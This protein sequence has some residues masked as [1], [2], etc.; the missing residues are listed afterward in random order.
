MNIKLNWIHLSNFKGIKDFK[1]IADGKNVSVFGNNGTGKTTLQD[2]WTWLLFDKD[3]NNNADTKF[4]IKPQDKFGQD[5]NHLQTVVEAELLVDGQPLKLKKLREEKWVTRHGTTEPVMDGHTK[6]YWFDEVPVKAKEYQAKVDN[7]LNENL[8]KLITNPLHFNTKLKWEERRQILLKIAGDATDEQVIAANQILGP[9]KDIL[10]GRPI[11]QYKLILADKLKELKKEKDDIPPR[12][13]EL[14]R[15]LPQ[16]EPDYTAIEQ[17]LTKHKET[18]QGI[19][20]LLT[21]ATSKADEISKKYQTLAKLNHQLEEVKAKIKSSVGSARETLIERKTELEQGKLLLENGISSLQLEITYAKNRLEHNSQVREN[22]L[23]EYYQLADAKKTIMAE[24][25]TIGEFDTTCPTCGQSIPED[26]VN[27]KIEEMKANFEKDKKERLNKIQIQLEQNVTEGKA[28]KAN[29]DEIQ[30][31]LQELENELKQKLDKANEVVA[32]IQEIELE[33]AK[34]IPEPNYEDFPEYTELMQKIEALKA[35]LDKPIEDKSSELLARKTEI[36]A[37]IDECK[38]LLTGK[39]ETEKKKTRIEQLKAEEK[40]IANLIAELEGHKYLL[41]QFIVTKVNLL[42]DKINSRFK[43]VKFKLFE[44]NIT[45]EGVKETCVALVNT[46]GSYVPYGDANDA[47]KLNSGI[48]IINTLCDF[49]SVRAPIWIDNR[50]R[51]TKLTETDSQVIS[52]I[53]SEPDKVLR[54][55]IDE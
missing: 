10:N 29:T 3:S 16:Q 36:Q 28:L 37:K 11:E 40:R 23:K 8:F 34:P 26:Q 17:E 33:L 15:S 41:D 44:E 35:E 2:A 21:N 20:F 5:I 32:Q 31:R 22:L 38:G 12:I 24:E 45:N 18:L 13:D 42:E 6:K 7:L 27:A 47:G 30:V 53:V 48:D 14:I 39:A 25:F 55:E 46:N 54:V 43:H 49:Y 50:E 52:L 51:V 19:E 1:L 9:L 4:T